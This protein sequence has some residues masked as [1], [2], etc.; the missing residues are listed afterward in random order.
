MQN[1]IAYHVSPSVLDAYG[2]YLSAD[3]D[4]DDIYGFADASPVSKADFIQGRLDNLINMV[5]GIQSTPNEAASL[6]TCFNEAID[7]IILNTKSTR[8]DVSL[9]SCEISHPQPMKV[10][11]AVQGNFKFMFPKDKTLEIASILKNSS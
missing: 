9:M 11:T 5:N 4:W 1:N 6:G 7:C 3:A 8:K 10:I 2:R